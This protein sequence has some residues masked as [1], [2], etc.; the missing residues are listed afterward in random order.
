MG[1]KIPSGP[2]FQNRTSLVVL[3]SL[4]RPICINLKTVVRGKLDTIWTSERHLTNEE[5]LQ[6]EGGFAEYGG[7][8]LQ[9]WASTRSVSGRNTW[10]MRSAA[11]A[12]RERREPGDT[13]REQPLQASGDGQR[14]IHQTEAQRKRWTW[15]KYGD[16]KVQPKSPQARVC[17]SVLCQQ[18][19][20]VK[21]SKTT[22]EIWRV[23]GANCYFLIIP[24]WLKHDKQ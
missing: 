16:I 17:V 12:A 14:F 13:C 7:H 24:S 2:C 5:M 19:N 1:D 3:R 23:N 6:R 4:S 21:Y 15:S 10:C 8:S 11:P 22:M 18:R 9:P 20:M